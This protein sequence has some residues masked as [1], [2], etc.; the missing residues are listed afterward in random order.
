MCKHYPVLH[1]DV[2]QPRTS[3][4]HW[5]GYSALPIY[6]GLFGLCFLLGLLGFS[7][8]LGYQITPTPAAVLLLIVSFLKTPQRQFSM[9]EFRKY[10]KSYQQGKLL[11]VQ[12]G[13]F[14]L[15]SIKN[16]FHPCNSFSSSFY[17]VKH[18][19]IPFCKAQHSTRH[20]FSLLQSTILAFLMKNLLFAYMTLLLCH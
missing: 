11:W 13:G 1:T 19:V 2:M 6:S 18:N 15:L 16:T 12:R 10:T 14:A 20:Y 7:P 8:D 17:A 4:Y 9:E 3:R 5:V